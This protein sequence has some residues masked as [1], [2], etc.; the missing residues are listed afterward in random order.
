MV[1]LKLIRTKNGKIKA[2]LE[3]LEIWQVSVL[4]W[5]RG[6][7][8]QVKG[9]ANANSLRQEHAQLVSTA[10]WGDP[11]WLDQTVRRKRKT[12]RRLSQRGNRESDCV[13]TSLLFYLFIF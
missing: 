9:T 11:E 2:R 13:G 12:I 5:G 6:N 8:L 4:G 1:Y 7:T 3:V 10:A